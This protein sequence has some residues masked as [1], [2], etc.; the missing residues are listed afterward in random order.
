MSEERLDELKKKHRYEAYFEYLVEVNKETEINPWINR[1]TFVEK[2]TFFKYTDVDW[3]ILFDKEDIVIKNQ[4]NYEIED[5]FILSQSNN[6][7]ALRYGDLFFPTK[8]NYNL[9]TVGNR[10]TFSYNEFITKRAKAKS[11]QWF[12]INGNR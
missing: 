11:I 7:D 9:P 10:L 5:E 3:E 12:V 6:I 4:L 1:L 8:E 2:A